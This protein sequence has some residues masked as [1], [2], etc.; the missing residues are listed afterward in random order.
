M[1]F[2]L[3]IFFQFFLAKVPSADCVPYLIAEPPTPLFTIRNHD[4]EGHELRVEV[5]DSEN[6]SVLDET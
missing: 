5:F 3:F 2:Y 4:S 6:N 1:L